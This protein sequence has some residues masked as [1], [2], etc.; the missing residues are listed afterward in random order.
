M[1]QILKLMG[2]TYILKAEK[3]INLKKHFFDRE[4]FVD[5]EN[6]SRL[7]EL[8]IKLLCCVIQTA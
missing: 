3:K 6:L 7:S 2:Q 4:R 8:D 1:Y 5:F